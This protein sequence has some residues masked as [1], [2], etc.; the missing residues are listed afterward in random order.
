MS[1]PSRSRIMLSCAAALMVARA[2]AEP[3]ADILARMDRAA[4]D[5]K[6]MSAKVK[7]VDYTDVIN[8][9]R[10]QNG[11]LR[12]KRGKGGVVYL[13]KF[14]DPDS[15]VLYFNGRVGEVYYPKANTVQIYDAGKYAATADR[16]LPMGFGATSAD[17]K[18]DYAIA[19]GGSETLGSVPTT[20]IEL[21]PLTKQLKDLVTKIELWIPEGQAHP[22]QAKFSEPSKDYRM[23]I[24]SEVKL[25]PSV[26]DS[27][28]ELKLPSG[29]KKSYPQK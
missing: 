27:E 5:F 9:T 4:K 8:E 18:K 11:E 26:P 7:E 29:V 12:L 14:G 2:H 28:F 21:T 22:V 24:Y 15:R 10:E 19:L 16:L 25:N 3:L 13:M 17:L 23:L 20:R 1:Y 6:S